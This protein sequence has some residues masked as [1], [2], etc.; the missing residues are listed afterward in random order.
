M[1]EVKCGKCDNGTQHYD[2]DGRM[3]SDTCY[4][5]GDYS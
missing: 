4:A 3:V 5:N 2:D 1:E